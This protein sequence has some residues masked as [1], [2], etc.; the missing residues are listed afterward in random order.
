LM[1]NEWTKDGLMFASIIIWPLR[2][3]DKNKLIELILL[4]IKSV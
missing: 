4:N 1:D 3:A 2:W